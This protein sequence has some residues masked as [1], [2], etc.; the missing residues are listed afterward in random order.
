MHIFGLS[1]TLGYALWAATCTVS[2]HRPAHST[3]FLYELTIQLQYH[4]TL[5]IKLQKFDIENFA[6]GLKPLFVLRFDLSITT[7]IP[8]PFADRRRT[9]VCALLSACA[10]YWCGPI[11]VLSGD[12]PLLPCPKDYRPRLSICLALCGFRSLGHHPS[13]W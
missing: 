4:N 12:K 1:D 8:P 3:S 10:W 5:I 13:A 2:Q 7:S 9:G 6:I 11:L